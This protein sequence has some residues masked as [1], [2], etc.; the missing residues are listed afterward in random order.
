MPVIFLLVTLVMSWGIPPT[1][2][3][4][5]L[6]RAQ[7]DGIVLVP[8]DD[9]AME[10]AFAKARATLPSF[11]ALARAPRPG[12]TS[13]AVKVGVDDGEETEYFW[14]T[15]FVER[16]GRINGRIGNIPRLVK[17]VSKGDEINVATKEVVDW[18]Y[19]ENGKMFGNFTGCVLLRGDPPA[20]VEKFKLYY[21]LDCDK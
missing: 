8:P 11:L 6:H 14:I 15:N 17:R 12:I 20:D 7:R 5:V 9:P 16:D 19:R 1:C 10:A 3:E 21:G 13:M 2:A 18:L 4:S